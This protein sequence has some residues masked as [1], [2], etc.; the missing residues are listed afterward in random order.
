MEE[1]LLGKFIEEKL[2]LTKKK[3]GKLMR[4]IN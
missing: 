2:F 1:N 3:S 4:T